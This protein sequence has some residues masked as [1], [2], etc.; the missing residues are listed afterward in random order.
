MQY[1]KKKGMH[2]YTYIEIYMNTKTNVFS[3]LKNE[4]S[5]LILI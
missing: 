5:Y 2:K 4:C 1:L 3:S